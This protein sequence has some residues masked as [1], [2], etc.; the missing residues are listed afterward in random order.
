MGRTHFI[1]QIYLLFTILHC[2]KITTLL[3]LIFSLFLF[4]SLSFFLSL[5]LFYS[6]PCTLF[7]N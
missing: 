6:L 1:L 4:L 2:V 3:S 5:S 7:L